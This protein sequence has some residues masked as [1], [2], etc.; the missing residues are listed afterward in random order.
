VAGINRLIANSPGENQDA[1]CNATQH[2][3]E[4]NSGRRANRSNL[5]DRLVHVIVAG[6]H[7]SQA[8]YAKSKYRSGQRSEQ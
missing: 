3:R 6:N 7:Q 2:D 8:S 4:G 5:A 1:G